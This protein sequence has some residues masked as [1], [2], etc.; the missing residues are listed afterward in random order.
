MSQLFPLYNTY[1]KE[2][3]CMSLNNAGKALWISALVYIYI[4]KKMIILVLVP[5]EVWYKSMNYT[6]GY[7]SLNTISRIKTL[8]VR[9]SWLL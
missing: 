8:S 7:N 1:L 6:I 9:N 5:Y 2:L 3:L 4:L